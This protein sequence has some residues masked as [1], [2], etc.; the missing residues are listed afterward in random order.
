MPRKDK[1]QIVPIELP[2][3]AIEQRLKKSVGAIHSSG[4]LT[5]V[6]RK[7][8][9]VLLYSAY[10]NLLAARTHKIPVS[11]MCAMLGWEGSNRI[12][13]LKEALGALQET[14]L[15]FNLREDGQEAWESMTMLSYA[16][17]KNGVCTYRYDE[18]LAERLFDPA[19]YALINLKVQRKLDTAYALNLYENVYRFRNANQGSTGEWS[20]QFF[21]EI[22]GATASY[23]DDYR[24]LNRK[25]IK[26]SLESINKD[27][28]IIVT[29]LPIKASR[30]TVG[31]KFFVREKTE[32]EQL[33]QEDSQQTQIPGT[34]FKEGT[35]AYAE[36][37]DT[38]AFKAL[39]KHGVAERLAFA[40]I[41]EKGE[42]AVLDMVAYTEER[43]A[44]NL[45][46]T[47]TRAYMTSLVKAGAEFNPSDYDREKEAKVIET[48]TK[49]Q[50]QAKTART[51]ELYEEYRKMTALAAVKALTKEQHR[52]D[53]VDYIAEVGQGKAKSYD[54][55]AGA[56]S[57]TLEKINFEVWQ[58]K[59]RT[60]AFDR[61]AFDAWLVSKNINPKNVGDLP[62]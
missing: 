9:N 8:A 17:I 52:A 45:I 4:K 32:K 31:M 10:D 28:D 35:D 51:A 60:P 46:K 19:M 41:R 39:K 53:A 42:S 59:M 14:R 47:N 34:S 24:E 18:A 13:H 49:E 44:Q 1:T 23:Y 57:N 6:Q 15:E 55:E 58:R 33:A 16:Q 38:P 43:D 50:D 54:K 26:P 12:D 61:T 37:R 20:L 27:T 40:W 29:M 48:K 25:I 21:R 2:V 11:I 3:S 36:L 56:F 22:I 7:L 62:T 5:L 30:Q